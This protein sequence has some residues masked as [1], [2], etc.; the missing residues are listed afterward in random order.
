MTQQLSKR[1]RAAS[2]PTCD[3]TTRLTKALLGYGVIAGP[4]YVLVSLAQAFTRDGFDPA[5]H[6]W[7]LLAN[8]GLGAIQTTNL[9]VTGSMTVAAAVGVRR[10]LRSG[11]GSRWGPRLLAGYGLGVFVA[12]VFKA[13]PTDGFPPGTPAGRNHTISWHGLA[14]LTSAGLGF[15]CLV[16]ACLVI[17]RWFASAGQ[18]QW[19]RFSRCTGV[20]FLA[21]F[22]GLASGAGNTALTLAFTAAV[23]LACGWLSALSSYLYRTAASTA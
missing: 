7:S 12:G 17:A 2:V 14:H 4:L 9:I 10:A 15:L 23:V 19:A 20:L 1:V 6:E 11:S 22:A 16:A 5:R 8:G 13:D 21:A 3:A 18:R